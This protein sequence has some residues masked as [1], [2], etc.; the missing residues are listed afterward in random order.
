MSGAVRRKS[1]WI[2]TTPSTNFGQLQADL[3]VDVAIVGGGLTGLTAAYQLKRAGFSVAVLDADR[4][5]G[6]A[7][8]QTSAHVSEV[9][10]APYARLIS[11]LGV[12][13]ARLACRSARAAIDTIESLVEELEISCS[14]ARLPAYLYAEDGAGLDII[15]EEL[16]GA[17]RAGVDATFVADV[18][19]PFA[20]RGAMMVPHQAQ[21]HPRQYLLAL[22]Y[23]I[24]GRGC[25][26][27]EWTPAVAI[28]E[29]RVCRV[30]TP[31]GTVVS[32]NVIV[33]APSCA[34]AAARLDSRLTIS[35]FH[36]VAARVAKAHAVQGL[37]WDTADPYHF[38]RA[39][40]AARSAMLIVGGEDAPDVEDGEAIEDEGAY[41]RLED[42]MRPRFRAGSV[43]YRW[44]GRIAESADALP[45]VGALAAR[46]HV[47]VAAGYSGSGM[48]LGTVAATILSDLIAARPNPYADLFLATRSNGRVPPIAG[49]A[50]REE[51]RSEARPKD[52]LRS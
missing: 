44:S 45:Y 2:A 20:T 27:Y 19:L 16:S 51:K 10:D 50:P 48:T 43:S 49:P 39:H 42:Y 6:G 46:S 41:R 4:V 47:Y 29:G 32:R 18:P 24:P 11:S 36:V 13:G 26:I 40:P 28:H 9:I 17:R 37:F 33:T 5:A 38:I 30:D 22:A 15:R 25:G 1:V 35:R 12:G 8:A 21:L 31:K 7:S 23:A 14:F 34:P 3:S 52:L